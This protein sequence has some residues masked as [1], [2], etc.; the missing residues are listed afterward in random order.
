MIAA[1]VVITVL[2]AA[3]IAAATGLISPSTE[4]TP[5]LVATGIPP[6][7]PAAQAFTARFS[8]LSAPLRPSDALGAANLRP[9]SELTHIGVDIQAARRTDTL[10]SWSTWVVPGGD[11]FCLYA[12]NGGSGGSACP[13]FGQMQ[14]GGLFTIGS[15][16]SG[17]PPA[18]S[19]LVVGFVPNGVASVSIKFSD[20]PDETLEV[21][22]NTFMS[23]VPETAQ[24]VSYEDDNGRQVR[25]SFRA[26]V[27]AER[28]Q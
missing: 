21:T 22:D 4:S 16:P 23:V 17:D 2:S 5:P 26:V 20:R 18:G 9:N 27:R 19:V 28:P 12:S 10:G 1:A 13:S 8:A 24:S 3:G 25:A 6:T 11:V 14:D 15:G 7:T